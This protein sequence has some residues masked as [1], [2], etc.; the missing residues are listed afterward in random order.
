MHNINRPFASTALDKKK[1]LNT[2]FFQ[3]YTAKFL[4]DIP[5]FALCTVFIF[6]ANNKIVFV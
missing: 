4:T 1:N 6:Q 3:N 5:E 2:D